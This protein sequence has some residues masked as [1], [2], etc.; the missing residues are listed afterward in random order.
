MSSGIAGEAIQWTVI[1]VTLGFVLA[2]AADIY[3]YVTDQESV[4]YRIQR[5]GQRYPFYTALFV[6]IFG[7]VLAHFFLNG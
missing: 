3:F 2:V 7:A 1:A 6:F 5:W 4:S